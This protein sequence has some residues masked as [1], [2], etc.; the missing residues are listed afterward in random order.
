MSCNVR[1]CVEIFNDDT[2][3][4]NIE[5]SSK[6]Y[7]YDIDVYDHA[8]ADFIEEGELNYGIFF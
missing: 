3:K 5:R 1:S 6:S 4:W 2:G 8:L 7:N